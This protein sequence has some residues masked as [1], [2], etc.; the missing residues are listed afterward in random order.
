MAPVNTR[1]RYSSSRPHRSRFCLTRRDLERSCR[2]QVKAR[3]PQGRHGGWRRV[4]ASAT[5]GLVEGHVPRPMPRGLKRP[6]GTT[7]GGNIGGRSSQTGPG[8]AIVTRGR[9]PGGHRATGFH[10]HPRTEPSPGLQS[11]QAVEVT[12]PPPRRRRPVRPWASFSAQELLEQLA[13]SPR[14]P[15]G[16]VDGIEAGGV[17]SS[18]GMMLHRVM[19]ITGQG[20]IGRLVRALERDE[21]SAWWVAKV[22]DD[23][24]AGLPWRQ[25]S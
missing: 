10:R 22:L 7:Q 5:A 1:S 9:G 17:I 20:L 15:V 14:T 25:S 16:V 18:T 13:T 3:T 12:A 24:A 8:D 19:N 6:G 11:R 23:G 21:A 4:L 2:H